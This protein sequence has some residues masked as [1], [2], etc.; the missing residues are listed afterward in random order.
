MGYTVQVGPTGQNTAVE[1]MVF[2]FLGIF[3]I[4]RK[5]E[6]MGKLEGEEEK[7]TEVEKKREGRGEIYSVRRGYF[8][9]LTY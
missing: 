9:C 3:P 1:K 8:I 7:K 4:Q 2:P 6:R 5:E